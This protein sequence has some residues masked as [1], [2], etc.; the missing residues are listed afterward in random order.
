VP[1]LLPRPPA[2]G[3]LSAGVLAGEHLQVAYATNDIDEA[4]ALFAKRYGIAR[5]APLIGPL[6]QGGAIHVELAWAGGVMIEL[7][8]AAGEGSA[9]Y[10]ERLPGDRFAI[11]H[12]HLGYLVRD[13]AAWE[14]L[15]ATIA[16]G[17][18][19]VRVDQHIA[20]FMRQLFVEAPELGHLLEFLY[21]EPAGLA[22][23]FE[24]VPTN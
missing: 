20:G 9:V 2:S 11:V 22:F 5:F 12:H 1:G 7:L 21:P 4:K 3:A 15:H 8:A 14:S 10:T 6:P 17:G 13:A 16:G 24:A 18:W 23:L 19:T